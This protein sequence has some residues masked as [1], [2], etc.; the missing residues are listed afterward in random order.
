VSAAPDP[1]PLWVLVNAGAASAAEVTRTVRS[2]SRGS[3]AATDAPVITVLG[4]S[5]P[6]GRLS[7]EPVDGASLII[8]IEAGAELLPG[9]LARLSGVAHRFDAALLYGDGS[10]LIA[11][12]RILVERPDFSPLRLL[13][14]DYLGDV[15][16]IAPSA[17]LRG[18]GIPTSRLMVEQL[19]WTLDPE[20]VVHIPEAL[21]RRAGVLPVGDPGSRRAAVAEYLAAS[22]V[23]AEVQPVAGSS[24]LRVRFVPTGRSTVSIIIPTRGSTA[25]VGGEE[26]VLVVDAVRSIVEQ[27]TYDSYDFVIVADDVVPQSVI[28]QLIGIGGDRITLTRWSQP[29][30][31]PGKINR[32]AAHAH[33]D[34]FLL[35][36]D[37]I[38]LISPDWLETM[39]GIIEQ[40]GVGMVGANLFFED[41][42]VQHGGHLY[43]ARGA[44][45]IAFGWSPDDDDPLGSMHVDR[46]VSGVTAACA[47]I[48]RELFEQIGGLS[49][50]LPGNYNDVDACLKV[51]A[52]GARIIWTPWAK[53]FHYESQTRE[54]EAADAELTRLRTRWGTRIEVD[55]FWPEH[56]VVVG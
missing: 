32:G 50:L 33:G 56:P 34:H 29:F 43:R 5:S 55:G 7:A 44:D 6:N 14:Q 18:R 16:A 9:A 24:S 53:L 1:G 39:V 11:G 26:R 42:R 12:R 17:I 23:A 15:I 31:F 47:M 8:W 45:H 40:P 3:T 51:R 20:S 49:M 46:E 52:T 38:E 13:E 54:P 2:L 22:G 30:N 25:V 4:A 19:A 21:T 10:A 27:S 36:N 35:L 41:G 48:S 37:D 28:D